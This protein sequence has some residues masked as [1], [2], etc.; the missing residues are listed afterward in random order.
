MRLFKSK[1]GKKKLLCDYHD[2]C[3]NKAYREVYPMMLKGKE[4]RGWSYLCRKYYLQEKKKY[5][6]KLPSSSID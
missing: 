5:K 1:S 4:K 6:F 2:N 3:R